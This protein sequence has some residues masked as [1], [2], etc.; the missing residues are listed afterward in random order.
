MTNEMIVMRITRVEL[1]DL[2]LA[3]TACDHNTN[4]NTKK[5]R[6]LHDKLEAILDGF[7]ADERENIA[8]GRF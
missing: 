1:C 7:D 3:C 6:R 4:E 2:L 5:W 8:T